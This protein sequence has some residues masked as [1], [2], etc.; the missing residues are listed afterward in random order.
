MGSSDQDSLDLR[1]NHQIPNGSVVDTAQIRV[2]APINFS[3]N[4]VVINNR[5][6]DG[7]GKNILFGL[8]DL[9]NKIDE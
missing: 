4:E 1:F 5:G 3:E 9:Q 8:I 2:A 6:L 7:L